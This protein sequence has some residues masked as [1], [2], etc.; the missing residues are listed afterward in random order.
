M[1]VVT[2]QKTK[3]LIEI[4]KGAYTPKVYKSSF[5]GLGGRFK[6][7]YDFMSSKLGVDGKNDSYYWVWVKNPF[8]G[9]YRSKEFVEDGYVCMLLDVEDSRVLLSDYDKYQSLVQEDSTDDFSTCLNIEDEAWTCVQGVISDIKAED[10][11]AVCPLDCILMD[12]Y[13]WNTQGVCFE[14]LEY[15]VLNNNF[16]EEYKSAF[17]NKD[18]GLLGLMHEFDNVGLVCV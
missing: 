1:R 12:G 3:R 4:L 16:L 11:I 14:K 10:I 7:G 6:E 15:E 5:V 17:V 8:L 2:F 18:S 13:G 9:F